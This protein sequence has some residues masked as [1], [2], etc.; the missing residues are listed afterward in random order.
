MKET[1]V[2]LYISMTPN[3]V[4][5]LNL[6]SKRAQAFFENLG[7]PPQTMQIESGMSMSTMI[8]LLPEDFVIELLQ[9][10]NIH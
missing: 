6:E 4:Y 1:K 7:A 5:T 9:N 10:K 3:G 2:D 8:S